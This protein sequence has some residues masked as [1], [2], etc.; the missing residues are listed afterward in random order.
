MNEDFASEIEGIMDEGKPSGCGC[1]N[2]TTGSG[3]LDPFDDFA[4]GD[5]DPFDEFELSGSD[6]DPFSDDSLDLFDGGNGSPDPFGAEDGLFELEGDGFDEE[7]D[8][9]EFGEGCECG[10][11][12]L[13][14]ILALA[15]AHPG[16]KISF[17]F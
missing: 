8:F 17:G 4:A 2:A 6:S 11:V 3:G 13:D 12:T 14:T 15:K 16:L 9:A 1:Q 10:G 7:F 5:S